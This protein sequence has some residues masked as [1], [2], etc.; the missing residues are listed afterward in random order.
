MC[1]RWIWRKIEPQDKDGD[2]AKNHDD[3]EHNDDTHEEERIGYDTKTKEDHH[4]YDE[5]DTEDHTNGVGDRARD[6]FSSPHK[7]DLDDE[8]DMSVNRRPSTPKYFLPTI[9]RFISKNG[10]RHTRK[11]QNGF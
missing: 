4:N 8:I 9:L 5:D 3:H 11:T 1:S 2:S 10:K 7:Y 6:D